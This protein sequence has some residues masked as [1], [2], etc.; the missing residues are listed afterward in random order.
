MGG[1]EEGERNNRYIALGL[2]V[3]RYCSQ[4]VRFGVLLWRT[5]E[6]NTKKIEEI[7]ME[8]GKGE[9]EGEEMTVE[10]V[11]MRRRRSEEEELVREVF[12]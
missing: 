3:V 2:I 6:E 5:K 4:V 1:H 9:G 8:D 7:V 11:V 10:D 12:L